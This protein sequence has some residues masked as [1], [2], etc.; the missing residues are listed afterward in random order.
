MAGQLFKT[1]AVTLS[2][3][4]GEASS[5][6]RTEVVAKNAKKQEQKTIS[7]GQST[8]LNVSKYRQLFGLPKEEALSL[9]TTCSMRKENNALKDTT[10]QFGDLYVFEAHLCFDW[11]VFGFHKQQV[12]ERTPTLH[13]DLDPH[14][15]HSIF[16]LT[17]ALTLTPQPWCM[18]VLELTDVV[19]L[20]KSTELPNT[21]EVQIKSASYELT[22]PEDFDA[23]WNIMEACR[24]NTQAV[25]LQAAAGENGNA[26][27]TDTYVEVDEELQKVFGVDP[28]TGP[29]PIPYPHPNPYPNPYPN[30]NCNPF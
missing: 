13:P 27:R 19:A 8:S 1:L 2:D 12:L 6:M 3:R 14:P 5:K 30:P 17:L 25:R 16:T 15:H 24:R 18:Q 28:N 23:A 11:K 26:F 22:I 7:G 9:R 29:D 4:I 21:V 10:V 20:L